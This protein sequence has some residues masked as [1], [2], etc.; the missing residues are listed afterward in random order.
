[1]AYAVPKDYTWELKI[2]SYDAGRDR[3]LRPSNQLKLQQEVGELHLGIG[4]LDY[5]AFYQHGMVFVLTRT[6][7]VI[8][9]APSVS[10]THLDVYKRQGWTSQVS[11]HQQRT[12]SSALWKGR[13][14]RISST[15]RV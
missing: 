15:R 3:R 9:R 14:S 4:G 7:T 6:R 12:W 11:S 10:Y 13:G 2:A 5:D 8:H 1:M